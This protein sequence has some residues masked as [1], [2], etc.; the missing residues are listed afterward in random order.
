MLKLSVDTLLVRIVLS[1]L[2]ELILL[3]LDGEL[4]LLKL[5]ELVEDADEE[6]ELLESL[7]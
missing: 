6:E 5:F 1:L 7:S 4:S 2:S 3:M